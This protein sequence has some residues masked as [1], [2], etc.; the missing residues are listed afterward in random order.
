MEEISVV[1]WKEKKVLKEERTM[2]KQIE[3]ELI[4]EVSE[5]LSWFDTD[6]VY[7]IETPPAPSS[8]QHANA[9]SSTAKSRINIRDDAT[10][11]EQ[12]HESSST[13]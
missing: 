11:S 7:L 13:V 9:S 3:N 12:Q 4:A 8:R 2:V 5:R 1:N 6:L 10:K